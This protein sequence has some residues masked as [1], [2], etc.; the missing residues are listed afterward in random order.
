[1]GKTANGGRFLKGYF[2]FT[3]TFGKGDKGSGDDIDA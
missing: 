3:A 2:D 1:M